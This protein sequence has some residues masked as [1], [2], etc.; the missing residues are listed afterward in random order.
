MSAS[1][2]P[3]APPPGSGAERGTGRTLASLRWPL[4]LLVLGVLVLVAVERTFR[5]VTD[6]PRSAVKEAADAAGALAERFKTG[7]ITST[8]T[9]S[10]PR[11]EPG[12][13]KLELAAYEAT[14]VFTRSD[15]RAILFELIPLGTTVSEIRVPVTYRYHVRLD[16]PWHLDVHGSICLVRAPPLRATLPPAIHTDRMEKRSQ[17]GWLRFDGAEQMTSLERSLTPTL[18]ARASSPQNLT[19]VRETCRRRVAEFVRDW[20]LR[21]GQWRDDSFTAV[22]VTFEGETKD[23]ATLPEPT[24]RRTE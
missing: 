22:T 10:L 9:A 23:P 14:E 13:S 6:V 1:G 20:L 18:S 3:P 16:D 7:R 21:E 4:T 24:L 15:E 11:L 8:F 2:T 12:G 17:E 5:W 19:L